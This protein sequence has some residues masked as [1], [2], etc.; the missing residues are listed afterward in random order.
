CASKKS[1]RTPRAARGAAA[2]NE[3]HASGAQRRPHVLAGWSF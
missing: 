3:S 2:A 1:R